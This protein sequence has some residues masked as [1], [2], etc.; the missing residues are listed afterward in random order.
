MKV[1]RALELFVALAL[2]HSMEKK[3]TNCKRTPT[4]KLVAATVVLKVL[5]TLILHTLE[6][7]NR[8]MATP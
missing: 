8:G 3:A 6:D 7:S 5:W 2:D 1:H 4:V